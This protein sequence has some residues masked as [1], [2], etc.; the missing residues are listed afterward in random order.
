YVVAVHTRAQDAG[1]RFHD[2]VFT[3]EH[4][5]E[6]EADLVEHDAVFGRL[7]LCKNKMIAGG[8]KGF[9]RDAADIETGTAEFFILFDDGGRKSEL[10]GADGS[11]IA[12]RTGA[13]D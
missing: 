10:G 13:D 7:F 1:E 4:G 11:D 6:V 3:T 2:L 5:R 12:A 9:A 8:E